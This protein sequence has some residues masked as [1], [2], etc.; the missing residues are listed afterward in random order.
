[1]ASTIEKE[2]P[3]RTRILVSADSH[4]GAPLGELEGVLARRER[5]DD[6][7]APRMMS[8]VD[9]DDGTGLNRNPQIMPE[10]RIREQDHDGVSAEVIYGATGFQPG[11]SFEDAVRRCQRTND[12]MAENY[13]P[14]LHR[15]AP[16][17]A[18]PL[19]AEPYGGKVTGDKPE[20]EHIAAAAAELRRA[21]GLGLRPGLMLDS[22][23]LLTYNRPEWNPIWEAACETDLALSFHVGFGTNPVRAHGPGGAIT[24]YTLVCANIIDT[25]AHLCAGGVLETFPDLK[26]VMT[27]CG[28]G[29][30]AWTMEIMDEAYVKHHHWAKP[31]LKMPPS[32]YAKRQ[33]QVTFQE[34]PVA[35]G[36]RAFTG[37]RCLMWG[38]DY[39][40]WEGTWPRSQEAVETQFA[41]VPED[42][43]DQIVRRNAIETFKFDLDRDGSSS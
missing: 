15:F 37:L 29:W 39:P 23:P 3:E 1:M 12:W 35:I 2:A 7:E 4:G 24:N 13:G 30:L 11:E 5:T 16:S 28:G 14:Y 31:K 32:E 36:N 33:V 38:S 10:D 43:V 22:S 17:I 20:P 19:P 21:A 42:E 41:G 6:D 27:E 34:D 26:V 9:I 18:L 40:H 8:V 25:V